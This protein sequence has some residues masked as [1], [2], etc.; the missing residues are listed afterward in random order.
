MIKETMKFMGVHDF[1]EMRETIERQ[2]QQLSFAEK[3][4]Y[5]YYVYSHR[6]I[7]EYTCDLMWE[8]L[9]SYDVISRIQLIQELENNKKQYRM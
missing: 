8:I 5:K 9:N 2:Y 3:Q 4:M 6:R 7:K 1:C